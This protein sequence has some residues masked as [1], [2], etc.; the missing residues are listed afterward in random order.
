MTGKDNAAA[1]ADPFFIDPEALRAVDHI[2]ALAP[3]GADE[4]D[5][6]LLLDGL[7]GP[8]LETLETGQSLGQQLEGTT[9]SF[10]GGPMTVL[11]SLTIVLDEPSQID[12]THF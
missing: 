6:T 9:I 2:E 5:I 3:A 11:P 8:V 1:E 10:D 4:I 7:L 12:V